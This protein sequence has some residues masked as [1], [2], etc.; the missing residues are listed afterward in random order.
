MDVRF[1][2]SF[3]SS[4]FLHRDNLAVQLPFPFKYLKSGIVILPE[5]DRRGSVGSTGQEWRHAN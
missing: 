3:R 5:P 4:G 1:I 2:L